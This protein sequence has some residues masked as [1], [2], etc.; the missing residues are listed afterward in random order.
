M[1]LSAFVYVVDDD[2]AVRESLEDLLRSLNY[3]VT[4]YGSAAEFLNVELPDAPH[5]W[6]STFG[7]RE[8]AGWNF[9]SIWHVSTSGCLS[10]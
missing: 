7:R 6:C 2:K 3:K 5:V 10:F 1:S 8:R 4:L 9:K